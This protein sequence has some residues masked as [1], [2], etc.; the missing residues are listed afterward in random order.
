MEI[1]VKYSPTIK[2]RA[3][4]QEI[5]TRVSAQ[6]IELGDEQFIARAPALYPKIDFSKTLELYR[7]ASANHWQHQLGVAFAWFLAAVAPPGLLYALG[8]LLAWVRAGFRAPPK[9]P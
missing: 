7:S 9:Q 2:T 3:E 1:S 8:L 6:R 4:G 5:E